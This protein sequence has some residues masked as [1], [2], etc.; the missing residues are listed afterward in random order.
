MKK[1][2]WDQISKT[3]LELLGKVFSLIWSKR[4]IIAI[5]LL[6]F[7]VY[8][9]SGSFWTKDPQPM[10]IF[11]NDYD[12]ITTKISIGTISD[13]VK[14]SGKIIPQKEVKIF[15]RLET[16]PVLKI[17]AKYGDVVESGQILLELDTEKLDKE[18]SMQENAFEF[19]KSELIRKEEVVKTN[20]KMFEKGY[21]S[22]NE[23]EES[24]IVKKEYALFVDEINIKIISLK[25]KLA[26]ARIVSPIKGRIDNV[27]K[28][29][30]PNSTVQHNTW[31]FTVS[32][33]QLKLSLSIDG[34]DIIKIKEGQDVSFKIDFNPNKEFFGTVVKIVEPLNV[35]PHRDKAP[36]FYELIA[37][38]EGDDEELRSGLSVDATIKI[39]TKIDIKR[40]PR[41]ALR[42]VPPKIV[43]I[44][45][46]P[47]PNTT[48][49]IIWIKN[50]DNSISALPIETGIRDNEFIEIL[51][52]A[53][54]SEE[55]DIIVNVR[56]NVQKKKK[57]TFTLPQPKRY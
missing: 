34:R 26:K 25:D 7:L 6:I 43:K 21:I 55:D 23:Y 46:E 30:V 9:M 41:T 10:T 4:K 22:K 12:L 37:I 44:K 1:I 35:N 20:K 16:S 2:N 13:F 40:I 24:E 15:S 18:I 14:A 27:E 57:S 19:K 48:T 8:R 42:F 50:K 52:P 54:L 33:D 39:Q 53:T 11:K 3:C 51:E 5:F 38:I 32:S 31:V 45:I 56:I 36:V 17:N 28:S 47:P 49:P 29:L